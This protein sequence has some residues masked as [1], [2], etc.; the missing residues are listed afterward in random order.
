[1]EWLTQNWFWILIFVA[2]IGMHMFGH[3][4]HGGHAGHG[5]GGGGSREDASSRQAKGT[6]PSTGHQH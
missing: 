1:M 6:P 3:G 4:G 2:F 5:R